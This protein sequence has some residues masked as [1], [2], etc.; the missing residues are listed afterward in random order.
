[1]FAHNIALLTAYNGVISESH[2]DKGVFFIFEKQIEVR[3]CVFMGSFKGED[4]I[5]YRGKEKKE[6]K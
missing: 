5:N 1:L 4:L 3:L 2:Q 6:W